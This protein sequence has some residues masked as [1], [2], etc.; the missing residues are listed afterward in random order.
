MEKPL[1]FPFS[2]LVVLFGFLIFFSS[3]H[4]ANLFLNQRLPDG[5]CS[6]ETGKPSPLLKEAL[7][8]ANQ[9]TKCKS[10][11]HMATPFTSGVWT[12]F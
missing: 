7:P 11:W 6:G 10:I 12:C 8:L 3:V 2:F 9:L 4:T 5:I 1:I